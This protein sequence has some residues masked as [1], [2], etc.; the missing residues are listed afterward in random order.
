MWTPE[1]HWGQT[2]LPWVCQAFPA[3]ARLFLL[4]MWLQENQT[5]PNLTQII[6]TKHH[7]K[8]SPKPWLS[9]ADCRES[10]PALLKVKK[11]GKK[12]PKS[13]LKY[14]NWCYWDHW[15]VWDPPKASRIKHHSPWGQF[16]QQDTALF[17]S[18]FEGT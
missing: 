15:A 16:S 3:S 1:H 10:A 14:P 5:N 8:D 6:L 18:V 4:C 2:S 17:V 13:Q 9:T 11:K 7:V 12:T